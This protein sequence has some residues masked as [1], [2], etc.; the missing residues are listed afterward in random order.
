[1]RYERR[2]NNQRTKEDEAELERNLAK[3]IV[4]FERK[5][6]IE[7]SNI[8]WDCLDY[9]SNIRTITA[10]VDLNLKI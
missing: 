7:V 8:G 5:Y 4:D 10:S 6:G 2:T 9:G 1:L 3:M